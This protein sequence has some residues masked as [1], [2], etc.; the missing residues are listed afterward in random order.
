MAL[1][2]WGG[3]SVGGH[4]D[5]VNTTMPHGKTEEQSWKAGQTTWL[6]AGKHLPENVSDKP[7]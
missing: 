5:P 2:V 7:F 3:A 4:A 1:D 6:P